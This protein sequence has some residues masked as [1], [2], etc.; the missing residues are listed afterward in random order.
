MGCNKWGLKGRLADLPGDRP[1]SAF[2]ALFLPFSPFSGGCEE[3]LG[4]L[5]KTEEK[6][7]FP[8]ISSDFLK[9]P[10]LK[11]PFAALQIFW[12]LKCTFRV[13]AFRG[14]VA[15]RAVGKLLKAKWRGAC[16]HLRT[17]HVI[18]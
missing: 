6:G 3:H 16:W 11:P 4:N 7:R 17:I 13:S 14:S 5:Q 18:Q 12:I 2:F 8:Q 1:K 10:S 9:L 15:G